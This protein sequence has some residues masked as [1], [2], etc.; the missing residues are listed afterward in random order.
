MMFGLE[1]ELRDER[2][3]WKREC[4]ELRAALEKLS[5][6]PST[7]GTCLDMAEVKLAQH[8]KRVEERE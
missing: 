4:A 7:C 2:D 6:C 5:E 1:D 8:K 3:F